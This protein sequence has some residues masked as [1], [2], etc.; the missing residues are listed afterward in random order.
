MITDIVKTRNELLVG[1]GSV[2]ITPPD[3]LA[4]SGGLDPRWNEGT[5]TP[6]MA[7]TLYAE[8]NGNALAVVGVDLIG[9]PRE[10]V[11][12]IIEKACS[13][14][15]LEP[16]SIL[17]CCSHTHSGPYIRQRGNLKERVVD[18]EYVGSLPEQIAESVGLAVKAAQPATMHMGRALVFHVLHNRRVIVKHDGLAFNTWMRGHL[19][20]LEAVPQVLGTAGPIDP[21]LWVDPDGRLW[22][23]WAQKIDKQESEPDAGVWAIVTDRPDEAKPQWSK[24]R[25]LTDGIMMCKPTVLSTGEW[26]MPAARW[27]AKNGARMVVSSDHGKTW[28]E[29]GA[30]DVPK[31]AQNCDEHMIVEKKDGTLWMWVRTL[32]GIGES[33]SRDRGRTWSA[34]EPSRV[35]HPTARFFLRRLRSGNLLLVKHGPLDKR[36]GRSHLTAYVSRDDG[37]SWSGGL[38][39]D[40]RGGISYP[41]GAQAA[42]GAIYITYDFDRG[43]A[44]EI[45]MAR[46]T[47]EDIEQ[48]AWVSKAAAQRVLV[49]KAL[50]PNAEADGG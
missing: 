47:E 40:E 34:L 18:E 22:L 50:G 31:E 27:R 37:A 33:V 25:R 11:D 3:G 36:I 21:E 12:T 49:H 32:Y 46:F 16:A 8:S 10:M 44:K 1:F 20:D 19:D 48:G 5:H 30:C 29:R 9:I 24:P 42:D 23:F 39:L 15:G 4:I 38:L 6:L 7:K 14:T 41:D 35:R 43:G 26:A 28:K 2:D 45:L 13:R 17:I